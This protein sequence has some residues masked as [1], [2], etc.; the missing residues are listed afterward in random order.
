[1]TTPSERK[2]LIAQI[3]DFPAKLEK[4]LAQYS[5]AQLDIPV[6]KG[7]W[8]VRQIVHHVADAHFNGYIRMRLVL[9]ETK[10]IIKPYDQD[11]WAKLNDVKLP[12]QPSLQ[13]IRGLHE[14]WAVMLTGLPEASWERQGVHLDNG[15]MTLDR[16]LVLYAGHGETHLEQIKQLPVSK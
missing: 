14:R 12:L 3:R 15:L 9:T 6:R 13:I 1:M 11:A 4:L 16:L 7:E 10:P 5:E 2:D 8:T